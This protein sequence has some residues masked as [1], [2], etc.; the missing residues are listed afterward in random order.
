VLVYDQSAGT[1]GETTITT[2]IANWD[3]TEVTSGLS[4][5]D[6]VVTTVDREGVE[7]GAAV[8]PE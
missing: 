8:A 6:R 3:Y 4:A 2:G 7:D 5:G 1:I